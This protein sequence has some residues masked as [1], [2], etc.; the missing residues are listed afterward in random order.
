MRYGWK[1]KRGALNAETEWREGCGTVELSCGALRKI[2]KDSKIRVL[3]VLL[4]LPSL[5]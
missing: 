2:L 1:V 3:R 5:E 4:C